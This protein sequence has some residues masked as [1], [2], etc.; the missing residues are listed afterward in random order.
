MNSLQNRKKFKLG[1]KKISLTPLKENEES[2]KPQ[3]CVANMTTKIKDRKIYQISS[4]LFMSGYES[5]TNLE[6][7]KEKQI[8]HIINLT[9]HKTQNM[10]EKSFTYSNYNIEDNSEFDLKNVLNDIIVD[11]SK[12][13]ATGRKV[14]VHCKMGIS[15]A[16][17]IILAFMI[18]MQGKDYDNAYDELSLI[19]PKI[20][21]NLGFLMLLKNI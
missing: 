7:L 3:Q 17:S 11:I 1:L 8:N 2:S 4:H 15:R 18:R 9:A 19:N 5:A 10:F 20:S 14:L 13:V 21:P 6:M 16:P 12:H